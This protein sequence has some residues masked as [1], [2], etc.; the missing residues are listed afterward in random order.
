MRS[1]FGVGFERLEGRSL[2]DAAGIVP[3]A[4][5]YTMRTN[6]PSQILAVLA[7]DRFDSD[8]QGARRITAVSN[9]SEGGSIEI[10][11]DG[12]AIRY[13]PPVGFA[14]TERFSYFVDDR[15]LGLVTIA[16]DSP[17]VD[18]SAEAFPDGSTIVINVL[19]NDRFLPGEL[20]PLRITAVGHT[21][22]GGE[23]TISV[24]GKSIVYH[25]PAELPAG[26]APQKDSMEDRFVYVVDDAWVA[27]VRVALPLPVRA[28][29]FTDLLQN[30]AA[31]TLNLLGNDPFWAS[32][33][34]ER[35]ITSVDRDSLR[36]TL[37][38]Q[39]DGQ[40]VA[41]QPAADFYG[42]ESFTYVVDDRY[43]AHVTVMV[44]RPV[45]DDH[46]G[47][48]DADGDFV[49]IELLANDVYYLAYND[50]RDAVDGITAVSPSTNGAAI[51]IS[52]DRQGV[53]YRP[54][55][56]FLGVDTFE[57][58]ADDRYKA[59]VSVSVT[60]PV[61]DDI[62]PAIQDLPADFEPL[63]NDFSGAGYA[64]PRRIT[65][66]RGSSAGGRVSIIGDGTRVDYEPPDGFVGSDQFTYTVDGLL[67]AQVMVQ[68]LPR[69]R[70]DYF[71]FSCIT[72]PGFSAILD[73]LAN[74]RHAS[75]AGGQ[76]KITDLTPATDSDLAGGRIS[77][78][79]SGAGHADRVYYQ[80]SKLGADRFEYELDGK[81]KGTAGIW[82]SPSSS[83]MADTL[84]VDQNSSAELDLASN[85]F[86]QRN[87]VW[88][89]GAI[90][91]CD[92]Y[93]GP[94]RIDAITPPAHGK[95]HRLPDGHSIRYE[96]DPD[97][98]GSDSFSYAVDGMFVTPVTV[99]VVRWV[100]DDEFRVPVGSQ[101]NSL[102]VL[103]NDLFGNYTG[104]R[105]ITGLAGQTRGKLAVADD[106]QSIVYSPPSGFIG[107]EEFSYL[108]DGR[109]KARVR[110][111]VRDEGSTHFE[112]LES[113]EALRAYLLEQSLIRHA[114]LFGQPVYPLYFDIFYAAADGG[115]PRTA[116]SPESRAHSSTNVQVAGIDE[117]DL[118][119]VD[120]TYLYS[121]HGGDVAITRAWPAD[122][123]EVVSRSTIDGT[124]FAL[125]LRGDRLTVLS[126]IWEEDPETL[127][128]SST[129][130]STMIGDVARPIL[131]PPP[132]PKAT[133]LVTVLD[134][135]D[136]AAP[137]VVQRTRLEGDYAGSRGLGDFVY[138]ILRRDGLLPL[139]KT[140]CEP[141]PARSAMVADWFAPTT[142][143]V[144]ESKEEYL[145]RWNS[146]PSQSIQAVLPRYASSGPDGELTR[147]GLLV[148]PTDVYLPQFP[149]ADQLIAVVS[150]DVMGNEPGIASS[151]ALFA[152]SASHI[153]GAE[154]HL[155]V[156]DNS[157]YDA[158]STTI[159]QFD[160]DAASGGIE[161]SAEGAV[162][163]VMLNQFS[164]DEFRGDLRI[165]TAAH[166]DD[167]RSPAGQ[168]ENE[169]FVLRA[170]AGLLEFRG[171]LQRFALGE[172]I[173]S[174]RF[175][176]ERALVTTFR[177]VDP[178][179][180]I[181]VSDPESPQLTGQ[182]TLPGFSSYMQWIDREC[183][184]TV[185]R[186]T[187]A[188]WSGPTQ[189]ALFSVSDLANPF[190]ID[191]L[192][193]PRWVT[194]EA[195]QDHHAFGWFS[196]HAMLALPTARMRR[197]RVDRDGDGVRESSEIR[198][199]DDLV[200]VGVDASLRER[201][202]RGLLL[203]G[204]VANSSPV[205]R[206]AFIDRVLYAVAEE[207]IVAV[208]VAA[209]DRVLG[210]VTI[211]SPVPDP[212]TL[213]PS[214]SV[215]IPLFA[216]VRSAIA[217]SR[218]TSSETISLITSERTTGGGVSQHVVEVDGARALYEFSAGGT[219]RLADSNFQ[220]GR[221][222]AAS[223]PE[224]TNGDGILAPLDALLVINDL[225]ANGSRRLPQQAVVRQ[226]QAMA[227]HAHDVNGDGFLSALDA[228]RVINRLNR[229]I[230]PPSSEPTGA[231]PSDSGGEGESV[232]GP[233][234]PC[235]PQAV[236]ML[237][238]E[239]DRE[240]AG[241]RK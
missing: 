240:P 153:Y 193:L 121:I 81:Y 20:G 111:D 45:V 177:N 124:P 137:K 235:W 140:R 72:G 42:Q 47:Q 215:P 218:G 87:S 53:R 105:K 126:T 6:G 21:S 181:D 39:P 120:D 230:A 112:R 232:R 41:Y 80:I 176:G 211:E 5:A 84:V 183:V 82:L 86:S 238:A 29:T 31:V 2:L 34:F 63:A 141:V 57:Y 12:S 96:P 149:D 131:F 35:R 62:L 208:D 79:S 69:A 46:F 189:V 223:L 27:N 225:N 233:F 44:H 228:V 142:R 117:G 18:D 102:S 127:D 130:A 168:E 236:D 231:V 198:R 200:L 94:R 221:K 43:E 83:P 158:R 118:I 147:S 115:P 68:V 179:L 54:P 1:R 99:Q 163:G 74:D 229:G 89:N 106:G 125:Y 23:A 38:L 3:V 216:E 30:S 92:P 173:Q 138:L 114:G 70:D 76:P 119:E 73:P 171:S 219:I 187:S 195:E 146:E 32:Y 166:N 60:R 64:G 49:A 15:A 156:F 217:A 71:E 14:G 192:T 205:R 203:A 48:V 100:R 186:N 33:P 194:S 88:R 65:E 58:V 191:A 190:L 17:V 165:V 209:P 185:G 224:D 93:R 10:T 128:P 36:G 98:V 110:V 227:N 66:V 91:T 101:D 8:Y 170:D 150:I 50:R 13:A 103:V 51:V 97:F 204:T 55:A 122:E 210:S 11:D 26:F 160:W 207:G 61:R 56:D 134:V 144:Y 85:D 148:A 104:A 201:S 237:M 182:V 145:A 184:L 214:D 67:D 174:V 136:R 175:D 196:E 157:E 154:K 78:A 159:L 133:T 222:T 178:L 24:D 132:P 109:L 116:T 19:A 220:F 59:T 212:H 108:V 164:A 4:D 180:V 152:G 77:I 9:G 206:S 213:P 135:T 188:G 129:P 107:E 143:C 226:I 241:A 16:V 169:L 90:V 75:P 22:F 155:Y 167:R 52:D 234:D 123:I 28:D 40:S 239:L 139:P 95:V 151:N 37:A 199:E 25:A 162:P 161:L 202:D 7:N 172:R 197:V 113:S